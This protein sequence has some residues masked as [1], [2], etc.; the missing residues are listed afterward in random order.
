MAYPNMPK[1]LIRWTL[2]YALVRPSVRSIHPL[3][4]RRIAVGHILFWLAK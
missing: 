3:L 1:T 2:Y 4:K